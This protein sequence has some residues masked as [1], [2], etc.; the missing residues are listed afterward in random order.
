MCRRI[1]AD[2]KYILL[3]KIEGLDFFYKSQAVLRQ[4]DDCLRTNNY[5]SVIKQRSVQKPN[6]EVYV[7]TVVDRTPGAYFGGILVLAVLF[8]ELL[9]GLIFL[10]KRG[11]NTHLSKP[12][13]LSRREKR[14]TKKSRR[15]S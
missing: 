15:K 6:E 4:T 8:F 2:G 10:D 1:Y 3:L 13:T 5:L 7:F 9:G 14:L 11:I 12:K